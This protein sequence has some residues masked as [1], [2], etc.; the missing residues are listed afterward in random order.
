[1]E[2]EQTLTRTT[3]PTLVIDAV[4]GRLAAK[5]GGEGAV[6][7]LPA[8]AA[9]GRRV[10]LDNTAAV[11]HANA[12]VRLLA[13]DG[14]IAGNSLASRDMATT[15]RVQSLLDR[16]NV[17]RVVADLAE[18]GIPKRCYSQP[19][20]MPQHRRRVH[21]ACRGPSRREWRS[22]WRP[23]DQRTRCERQPE[24]PKE[25]DRLHV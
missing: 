7:R 13:C 23:R 14:Q 5:V 11:A 17:V 25:N 24:Q 1:M 9:L 3:A 15:A 12:D 8:E 19:M 2:H 22:Q 6:R 10:R 20:R 21:H 4:D 16:G 18:T